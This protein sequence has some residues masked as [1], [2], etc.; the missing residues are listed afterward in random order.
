MEAQRP[1]QAHG[2]RFTAMD[3][4]PNYRRIAEELRKEISQNVLRP[5]ERLGSHQALSSHFGVSR[6]TIRQAL[7]LLRKEGYVEMVPKKGTFVSRKA[8]GLPRIRHNLVGLLVENIQDPYFNE[9]TQEIE[10]ELLRNHFHMVLCDTSGAETN[11]IELLKDRVDGFIIAP[12]L[13]EA[14]WAHYRNLRGFERPYVLFDRNIRSIPGNRVLV[15]NYLGGQMA[16]DHLFDLGH[17]LFATITYAWPMRPPVLSH[18]AL[19]LRVQG[20]TDRLQESGVSATQIRHLVGNAGRSK[21]AGALAAKQWLKLAP[22]PAALFAT[23]DILCFGVIDVAEKAGL[24]MARDYSLVGFDDINLIRW[25]GIPLTTI[26]Q[27]RDEIAQ[28]AVRLL[29]EQMEGGQTG[30]TRHLILKPRIVVRGS[31]GPPSSKA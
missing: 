5:G 24:L 25:L 6:V 23:N 28:C 11:Y 13:Q 18:E 2:S 14:S 16:A 15:D 7:T 26:A 21:E 22:R 9:I 19:A 8:A 4:M 30:H 17:R 20:F 29:C 3:S 31:T 27:P 10:R 12:S 1:R